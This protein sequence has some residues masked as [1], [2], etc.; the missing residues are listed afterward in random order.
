MLLEVREII[1]C[2]TDNAPQNDVTYLEKHLDTLTSEVYF[3]HKE[4]KEKSLLIKSTL[5]KPESVNCDQHTS[6]Y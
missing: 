5:N 2:E 3:L 4:L 1:K 6:C